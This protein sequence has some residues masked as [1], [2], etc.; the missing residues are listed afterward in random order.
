MTTADPLTEFLLA[1]IAEVEEMAWAAATAYR[2]GL[3]WEAN[4]W[5]DDGWVSRVGT[6]SP[7][8]RD[9]WDT[10]GGNLVPAAAVA[11]HM[12]RHD[13]A[14]VLAECV[15]KRRIVELHSRYECD[16]AGYPGH[17]RCGEIAVC[18]KCDDARFPCDTLRLLALPYADHPDWREEWRP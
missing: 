17:E 12:A 6:E 13:P 2:S 11:V 9:L 18:D 14:R 4:T 5:K 15:A 3:H 7:Q 1:R 10:E 16:T 8:I